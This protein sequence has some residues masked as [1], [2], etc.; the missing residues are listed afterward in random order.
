M[1]KLLILLALVIPLS[2]FAFTANEYYLTKRNSGNTANE[3]KTVVPTS[4]QVL[5]FDSS[6]NPQGLTLS[7]VATSGS[8]A[9]LSGNLSVS[10]LNGG[11]GA[12]NTTYWRGD[13]TWAS[14]G[15]STANQTFTGTTTISEQFVL[16]GTITPTA[17]TSGSTVNDYNPTGLSGASTIRIAS[18]GG[19]AWGLTGV[20]GGS[21]GRELTLVNLGAATINIFENNGGSSAANRILNVAGVPS[22]TLNLTPNNS[23]TLRYDGTSSRWRVLALTQTPDVIVDNTGTAVFSASNQILTDSASV[24]SMEWGNRNFVDSS[25]QYSGSWDGRT[26][27]D[28]AGHTVLDWQNK[29]MGSWDGGLEDVVIALDWGN[30]KLKDQTGSDSI[31][32]DNRTALGADGTASIDWASRWLQDSSEAVS[33]DWEGR[34][35]LDD[36][37]SVAVDWVARSLNDGSGSPVASWGNG[38]LVA[39]LISNNSDESAGVIDLSYT[40]SIFTLNWLDGATQHPRIGWTEDAGI[41]VFHS[42]GVHR[43]SLSA[44]NITANRQLDVPDASG[45]L[46][47]SSASGTPATSGTMTVPMDSTVKT[48]T[49]AG[50]CTFNASDGV[51]GASCA[52]IITTSGTTPYTLTFGTNFKSQGT[53]VTGV[54][55][56]KKFTVSFVYDGTNWCET[57]RTTAM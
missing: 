43:L 40:G 22:Y 16:S 55:S 41:F 19:G 15:G 42:D 50:N 18:T 4:G 56:G 6:L 52:F 46:S 2:A 45:T 28:T 10:R 12:G 26:L 39:N 21:A 23:L 1:K 9:D 29:F 54:V 36:G 49:P 7:T 24:G 47:V 5:K 34:Q 38:V 25:G 14:A 33:V 3:Q 37:G 11:S 48:I 30:R 13:G 8:A 27:A 57:S 53:L 32:W 20:A 35:L 31:T 44:E 17:A 51:P